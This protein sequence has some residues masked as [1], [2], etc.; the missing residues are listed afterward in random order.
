LDKNLLGIT[1]QWL[2]KR[3]LPAAGYPTRG[4]EEI[5]YK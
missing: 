4:V 2:V 5:I 1:K 3:V